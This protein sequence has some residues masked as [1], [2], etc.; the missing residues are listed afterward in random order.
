[1]RAKVVA[2][3]GTGMVRSAIKMASERAAARARVAGM[4]SARPH[5]PC[6]LCAGR[7]HAAPAPWE[8]PRGG[9]RARAACRTS[10]AGRR[11]PEGGDAPAAWTSVS[12]CVWRR[13]VRAYDAHRARASGARYPLRRAMQ[14]SG[15]G[16]G[17]LWG[18]FF[19]G[20]VGRNH[21]LGARAK[22]RAHLFGAV[23]LSDLGLG[24]TRLLLYLL[25]RLH[26][27]A[28]QPLAL[29]QQRRD[30]PRAAG[31]LARVALVLHVLRVADDLAQLEQPVLGDGL[32]DQVRRAQLHEE[33]RRA[34]VER[35]RRHD[36]KRDLGECRDVARP[37]EQPVDAGALGARLQ[38]GVDHDD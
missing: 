21:S 2:R 37:I 16:K 8:C 35:R 27:L 13:N 3:D 38:L 11:R 28:L 24:A 31:R 34:Q 30:E 18:R 25:E 19:F 1:M 20:G 32:G 17:R 5:V 29:A 14:A 23:E 6:I 10:R 22:S 15:D 4:G 9:A 33:R 12:V 7:A 26:P 36:D